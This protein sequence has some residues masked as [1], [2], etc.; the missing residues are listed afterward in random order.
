MTLSKKITWLFILLIP[1]ISAC[2]TENNMHEN[3]VVIEKGTSLDEIVRRAAHVNPSTR[4]YEWQKLEFIAFIHFGINTFTGREWGMGSE[5]ISIFNPAELD[6]TQWVNV[7]RE[8][9]MKMIILTAKHH[10]GFCLW[11]SAYTDHSIANAP[12]RNGTGDIVRELSDACREAGLKNASNA[13][14]GHSARQIID[15]DEN[16][17]WMTD[18]GVESGWI[19]FDLIREQTFDRAMLQERILTGQRIEKFHLEYWAENKWHRFADGTTVGYKRLPQFP[20]VTARK[21]RLVIEESRTSPTLTAFGLYKAPPEITFKPE[22]SAFKD[23]IQ[24]EIEC[25]FE[26]AVI[27]FTL[28]GGQATE[29]SKIYSGPIL[30]KQNATLSVLTVPGI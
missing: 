3:Y 19:E 15:G 1:I 2:H 10:D 12:Y 18:D 14:P 25:D 21:I 24:V 26:N 5:D 23:S 16:T 29:A 7:C 9:G 30:L 8:A 20:A 22:E 11:P 17:W 6:V 28:N 27:Y 4:Q 13:K